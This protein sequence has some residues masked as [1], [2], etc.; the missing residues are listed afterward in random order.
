[1]LLFCTLVCAVAAHFI[2]TVEVVIRSQAVTLV[3]APRAVP[4]NRTDVCRTAQFAV[5]EFNRGNIGDMFAYKILNIT[6]AKTQ[7]I[8]K[9]R[10][11]DLYQLVTKPLIAY[12]Q[13]F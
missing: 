1:M 11:T 7:V 4:E 13:L 3:G 10:A 2:P 5:D 9:V 8:S 6:S 12:S